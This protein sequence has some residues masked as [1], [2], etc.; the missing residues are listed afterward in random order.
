MFNPSDNTY[1]LE[2]NFWAVLFPVKISSWKLFFKYENVALWR[3]SKSVLFGYLHSQI[4][5]VNAFCI[6]YYLVLLNEI[7][8]G[9]YY[10]RV[11]TFQKSYIEPC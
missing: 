4:K 10:I 11:K 8:L 1:S 7:L 5:A 6:T 3:F 9:D 2:V